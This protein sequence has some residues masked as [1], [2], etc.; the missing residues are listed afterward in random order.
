MKKDNSLNKSM[1]KLQRQENEI[2]RKK[3]K[4]AEEKRKYLLGEFEKINKKIIEDR[5]KN[6]MKTVLDNKEDSMISEE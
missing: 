3:Q 4:R 5:I 6:K 2:L 1:E